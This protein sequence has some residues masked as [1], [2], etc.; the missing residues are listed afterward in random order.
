[1]IVAQTLIRRYE[2]SHKPLIFHSMSNWWFTQGAI[3]AT[4]KQQQS[5]RFL[6]FVTGL[7]V[8]CLLEKPEFSLF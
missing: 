1:M 8:R 5:N 6:G 2:F 3:C 4:V 7:V